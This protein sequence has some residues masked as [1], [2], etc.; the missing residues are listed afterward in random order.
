[1]TL[2]QLIAYLAFMGIASATPGP[3]NTMLM[4]S[5]ANFGLKRTW[6]HMAGVVLGFAFL[7]TCVGLGLGALVTAAPIL[8]VILRYGGCAY[9]L[10]LAWKIATAKAIGG[11]E[12]TRPLRFWEVVAFQW[13]N[14]KAW[15]GAIGAISAYAPKDHPLTALP[16][17]VAG[18][19]LV[20]MP[21]VL[22]WTGAGAG[23][24]R[25]LNDPVRRRA[26]NIAMGLALVL[27]VIPMLGPETIRA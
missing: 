9:L 11:V 27:A 5:G 8:H 24:R 15:V 25:F 23:V 22:F 18:G 13:V 12:A 10:W 17:I 14:P 20:N 6:P 4:A 7:L 19:M 2:T 3:N 16:L 21:I 1:M 26:F